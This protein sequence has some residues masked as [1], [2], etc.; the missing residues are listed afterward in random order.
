MEASETIDIPAPSMG[1]VVHVALAEHD[2]TVTVRV[3]VITRTHTAG[4]LLLLGP[5]VVDI[6]VLPSHQSIVTS[7]AVCLPCICV[8]NVP[9]SQS[10]KAGTWRYPPFVDGKISVPNV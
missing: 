7:A 8:T 3:G 1:R 5:D 4:G 10:G 6:T 9:Y 2:G